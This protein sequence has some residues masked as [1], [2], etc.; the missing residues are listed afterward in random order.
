MALQISVR[1]SGDVTILDLGGRATIDSGGTE[2]LDNSLRELAAG[3]ARQVLLNLADVTQLDSSGVSVI[4][5][6]YRSLRGQGGD[7]RLLRPSN[8]ALEVFRALHLARLI[9]IFEDES[10]A[11]ASFPPPGHYAKPQGS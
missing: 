8:H 1:E 7:L 4:V 3:R 2:M 11:L 9:P 6:A 5:K 10:Q